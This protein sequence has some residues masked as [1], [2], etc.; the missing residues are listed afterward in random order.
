[1]ADLPGFIDFDLALFVYLLYS[2]RTACPL[3]T[4]YTGKNLHWAIIQYYCLC[5]CSCFH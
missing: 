2:V 5:V 1:M 3:L 4:W